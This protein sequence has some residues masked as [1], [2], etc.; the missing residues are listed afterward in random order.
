MGYRILY[1]IA[2]PIIHLLFPFRVIGR[3]KLSTQKGGF[4][5]CANHISLMDPVLIIYTIKRKRMVRFMAKQEVF[6]NWFVSWFLRTGGAFP[7]SRGAGA[8]GGV[9]QAE[10]VLAN[11]Q[12]LGIFPEGTRSKTGQLLKAKPGAAMLVSQF[13]TFV[14]PIVLVCKDQKVRPFRRTDLIICDPMRLPRQEE[15]VSQRDYLRLCTDAIMQPI[16]AELAKRGV[17]AGE[18]EQ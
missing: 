8:T 16:A 4:V 14:Q 7:V 10:N 3:E 5:I 18:K 2:W 17:P 6:K 15:G 13:D 12:I 1:A 9:K 11:D